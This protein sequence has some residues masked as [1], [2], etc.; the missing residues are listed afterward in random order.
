MNRSLFEPNAIVSSNGTTCNSLRLEWSTFVY[1]SVWRPSLSTYNRLRCL[2]EWNS[3]L[4]QSRQPFC[5]G[6]HCANI[7]KFTCNKCTSV[8]NCRIR[9]I[10][11][12]MLV[13]SF[14]FPRCMAKK[15]KTI[16]LIERLS[17]YRSSACLPRR[18]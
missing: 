18:S 17:L 6:A 12:Q 4:A 7:V 15:T 13:S 11:K 10:V 9:S 2:I 14:V 5:N 3:V 16:G 8:A 1:Q